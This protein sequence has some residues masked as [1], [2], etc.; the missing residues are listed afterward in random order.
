MNYVIAG[1]PVLEY[2]QKCLFDLAGVEMTDQHLRRRLHET[3]SVRLV[4]I[5]QVNINSYLRTE[6][7]VCLYSTN[8]LLRKIH[9]AEKNADSMF[10]LH[11][12]VI[13]LFQEGDFT[14]RR[15]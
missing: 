9:T 10:I 3:L 13:S 12:R 11:T 15:V 1:G 14:R 8:M 6:M 4:R 7:F 5:L 2:P